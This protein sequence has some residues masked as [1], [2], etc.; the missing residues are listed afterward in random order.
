MLKHRSQYGRSSLWKKDG[1][2]KGFEQLFRF[3]GTRQN[4]IGAI[5]LRV[6]THIANETAPTPFASK[7]FNSLIIVP[8]G[9]LASFTLWQSK[10]DMTRLAV[11]MASEDG[12]PFKVTV[13]TQCKFAWKTNVIRSSYYINSR[14]CVPLESAEIEGDK[15]GSPHSA[16]KKCWVWYV[17]LPN[18]GSSRL[19]NCS[20]M[21]AVLHE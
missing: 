14:K 8:N 3:K 17:R 13:T 18:A 10:A 12:E 7:G 2:S 16:Q 19:M 1:S 9:L 15:N 11:W 4:G 5:E 20:S 21:I 6:I